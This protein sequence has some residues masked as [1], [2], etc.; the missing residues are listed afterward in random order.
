MKILVLNGPNLNLLGQR[1]KEYY[2]EDDLKSINNWLREK[3]DKSVFLDFSQSN[4]EGELINAIH[5]AEKKHDAI[6]FNPGAFTHYAIG[7]RDA[8][9]SVDIP[10]IEVHMSN[11]YAREEF[12]HKSVIAPV[13][14]GKISGF[15]KMSYYLGVEALLNME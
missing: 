2:G 6:V 8:V 10:V 9:E 13:C 14:K 3:V 7:L 1:D 4:I 5:L 11:V 12:R 15:G